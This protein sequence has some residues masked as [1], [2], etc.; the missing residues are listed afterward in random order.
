MSK[1]RDQVDCARLYTFSIGDVD[2]SS[3]QEFA[4]PWRAQNTEFAQGPWPTPPHPTLAFLFNV[5]AFPFNVMAFP[6]TGRSHLME[7]R[8]QLLGVPSYWAFP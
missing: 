4:R 5:M 6:Y 1:E 7:W 8:S 3:P 2:K